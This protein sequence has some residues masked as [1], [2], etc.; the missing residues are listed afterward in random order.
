MKQVTLLEDRAQVRRAGSVMLAPG[1]HRVVVKDVAPLMQDLSLRATASANAKVIDAR[2]RRAMRVTTAEKPEGARALEETIKTLDDRLR[3]ITEDRAHAALRRGRLEEVLDRL[4]DQ[5]AEDRRPRYD[6]GD[7]SLVAHVPSGWFR[8][9]GSGGRLGCL[10]SEP[11]SKPA[12]IPCPD[13][14]PAGA[15]WPHPAG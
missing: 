4:P 9:A 8:V 3:L 2:V 10:P 7:A 14:V 15:R 12:A 6:E 1:Q 13:A 11:E 5:A